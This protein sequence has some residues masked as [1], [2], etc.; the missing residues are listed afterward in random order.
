M[1]LFFII[2]AIAS[3]GL[4][5]CAR[6]PL[7]GSHVMDGSGMI[8]PSSI[9]E[10]YYYHGGG[11]LGDYYTI[12]YSDSKV[13]MSECEGNGAPVIKKEAEA[14]STFLLELMNMIEKA[15]MR[16]WKDLEKKDYFADDEPRTSFSIDFTDG[17]KISF[18]SDDILPDE[19]WSA[20]NEIVEYME[21][22]L[23]E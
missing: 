21:S 23:E 15:G 17:L 14:D 12:K 22:V 11:D 4:V 8:N 1:T 10:V 6:S 2:I 16:N 5:A 9:D 3:I 19:G 7:F 13:F 18:D 20:V